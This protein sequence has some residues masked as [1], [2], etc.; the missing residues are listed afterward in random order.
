MRNWICKSSGF[1]KMKVPEIL[2]GLLDLERRGAV[3]LSQ[4]VYRAIRNAVRNGSLKPGMRLPS[5][6]GLAA[7]HG[8]SRNTVNAAFDLL[9]AEMIIDI[10]PGAAPVVSSGIALDGR[11]S[12]SARGTVARG[13]SRRGEVLAENLRGEAWARRYGKLQPGAPA[14]DAFPSELWARSLRRAARA[15][16]GPELLYGHVSGH[17]VLKN[18]LSDYL[19]G[20]RGVKARP[21]QILVTTSMQAALATLAQG[22]A[23]PGDL[24]W[25]EDPG[26][27]GARTA[28]YGAGLRIEGLDVD[29]EGARIP[30]WSLKAPPRLIYVTP[31]HQFPFG[32]RMSLARRLALIEAASETGA[33]ILED[34]YDSEFL[35]EGRPTAALQGLAVNNE[36]IYLGTLSK[37]LLPGLRLA[38]CVVPDALAEPVSALFRNMGQLANVHAQAALADFIESG[39]YRAHLKRI[40][41]LYEKRG[42]ALVSALR[43][44]LGNQVDVEYPTGNVQVV[45]RFREPLDDRAVARAVQ[46]RG[47]A[48]SPF[49]ACFLKKETAQTGLIMGFASA[50]DEDISACVSALG[51]VL[52]QCAESK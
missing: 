42:T 36:V 26:Y 44:A 28:F 16:Q 51:D 17:P 25:M 2:E 32:T 6:R 50:T 39:N 20:A 15:G 31:S 29:E 23:D 10:K 19:A 22:L 40:R 8:I 5:S 30:E 13:I 9:Q 34:D 27:L 3:P 7:A 1:E 46:E 11:N 12:E 49:S 14:L 4:Q 45:A 48:L 33:T 35:F 41:T 24:A 38:Y 47:F 21:E 18:V 43:Q 37:S 52:P